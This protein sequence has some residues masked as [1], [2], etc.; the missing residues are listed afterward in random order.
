MLTILTDE[1]HIW[2]GKYDTILKKR[3]NSDVKEARWMYYGG[4][5]VTVVVGLD[6]DIDGCTNAT[7]LVAPVFSI[8]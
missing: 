4:L 3:S 8:F 5:W 1:S 2:L 7:F 6:A